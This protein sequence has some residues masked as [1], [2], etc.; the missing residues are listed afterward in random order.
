MGIGGRGRG[1]KLGGEENR[2]I[3]GLAM[4]S[5]LGDSAIGFLS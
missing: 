4:P 3:K 1:V 2:E 5:G